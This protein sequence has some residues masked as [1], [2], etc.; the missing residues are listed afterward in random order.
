M[1]S[2]AFLIS[3]Y[4]IERHWALNI[5][6]FGLEFLLDWGRRSGTPLFFENFFI[7]GEIFMDPFEE[8]CG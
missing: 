3:S 5:L 2:F 4:H 7:L 8:L 1:D 6:I